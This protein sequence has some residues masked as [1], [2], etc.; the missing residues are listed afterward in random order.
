MFVKS[1]EELSR[2]VVQQLQDS[3]QPALTDITVEW[4]PAVAA[5]TPASIPV[6]SPT[7]DPGE[8]EGETVGLHAHALRPA[9]DT[10]GSALVCSRC[11]KEVSSLAV[12]ADWR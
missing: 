6:L 1:N 5:A 7:P 12:H 11:A 3:L 2:K 4:L 8:S 10:S 9:T